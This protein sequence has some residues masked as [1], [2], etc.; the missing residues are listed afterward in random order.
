MPAQNQRSNEVREYVEITTE[1]CNEK[2]MDLKDLYLIWLRL[3]MNWFV[4]NEKHCSLVTGS[5]LL[6]C[7]LLNFLAT[8]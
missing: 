5:Y 2:V 7:K 6:L 1:M 4:H 8:G 3:S